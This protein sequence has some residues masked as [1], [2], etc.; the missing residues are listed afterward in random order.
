MLLTAQC[1]WS[2][3]AGALP[4]KEMTQ[5]D[6]VNALKS[7][8]NVAKLE[9]NFHQ[10]KVLKD[11]DMS[12]MS[13]GRL[14]FARPDQVT[15]EIL[16]PSP[17][18]VELNAQE[19]RMHNGKEIQTIKA[20]GPQTQSLQSMITWLKLDATEIYKESEVFEVGPRHYLF[21]P[22]QINSSPF[23]SLDLTLSAKG[24]LEKFVLH[25][26]SG[27]LLEIVF[28]TPKVTMVSKK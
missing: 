12:L 10:K 5:I 2:I 20:G 1:I 14:T 8:E 11:L 4:G 3:A 13:E 27:D 26:K 28:Q 25:E 9:A 6:L 16:K 17:L 7:Y 21:K 19:I 18:L 24:F 15:W 23:S 22:R